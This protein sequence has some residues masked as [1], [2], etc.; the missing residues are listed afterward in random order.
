MIIDGIE[1]L[2]LTEAV[3]LLRNT[4]FSASSGELKQLFLLRRIAG[5]AEHGKSTRLW[6]N[7]EQ[8]RKDVARVREEDLISRY[9]PP[10]KKPR[11][12]A[13]IG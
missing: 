9:G 8:L 5:F 13:A 6:F 7:V 11:K 12:M 10:V 2:R 3:R 4:P 1:Y